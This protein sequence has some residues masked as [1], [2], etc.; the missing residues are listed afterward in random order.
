[1]L[2]NLTNDERTTTMATMANDVIG[3]AVYFEVT[4][5]SGGIQYTTQTLITPEFRDSNGTLKP[6]C[7]YRRRISTQA[8]KRTWRAF[9]N[10]TTSEEA[11]AHARGN[12]TDPIDQAAAAAAVLANWRATLSSMIER[13]AAG[14]RFYEIVGTPIVV[15]VT[16]A[17]A[18]DFAALRT[19]YKVFGRVWKARKQLG[20]PENFVG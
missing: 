7:I 8:P 14:N 18:E 11:I 10:N 3:A 16:S 12:A 9:A 20:F 6:N 4:R 5:H 2:T 15:E 13:T 17:D 1:V 19:P